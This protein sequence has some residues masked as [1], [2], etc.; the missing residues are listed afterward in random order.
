MLLISICRYNFRPKKECPNLKARGENIRK[1]PIPITTSQLVTR[2][3]GP[4]AGILKFSSPI[5]SSRSVR[6]QI[7]ICTQHTN[8]AD[9]QQVWISLS[10]MLGILENG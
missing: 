9:E 1:E 5:A 10:R 8:S 4:N 7:A 6:N 3:A 2:G